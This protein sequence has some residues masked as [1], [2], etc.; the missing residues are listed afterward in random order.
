MVFKKFKIAFS[1]NICLCAFVL[2]FYVYICLI[3]ITEEDLPAKIFDDE[4]IKELYIEKLDNVLET[5][6]F[7]DRIEAW[8]KEYDSKF[9]TYYMQK[10]NKY[11]NT[12]IRD[13]R[14]RDVNYWVKYVIDKINKIVKNKSTASNIVDQITQRASLILNEQIVYG[15]P[16][17]ISGTSLLRDIKKELDNFCENRDSFEKK[18]ENYNH[19]E[20]EKYKNY[21]KITKNSFI[22]YFSS[23]ATENRDYLKINEKCNFN[24]GCA[25][26]PQIQCDLDKNKIIRE[27][28]SSESERC[29]SSIK[30]TAPLS[31]HSESETTDNS[32]P[33]KKILSVS[34]PV[35]G[36]LAVSLVLYK[37]SPI[38]SWLH[39]DGSTF[40]QSETQDF[41]DSAD[42]LNTNSL[43]DTYP[44]AYHAT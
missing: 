43:S 9:F 40:H 2:S 4:L 12:D 29:V 10:W 27:E 37:I 33:L 5:E 35:A 20:C 21:I 16:L 44:I 41:L 36:A 8:Y 7:S 32:F 22:K 28:Q 31:S 26:F 39:G 1:K 34:T 24:K 19:T 13:K 11:K 38:G 42:L 30:Y 17:D 6:D 25:I 15:C 3:T 14:C 23:V 18:L